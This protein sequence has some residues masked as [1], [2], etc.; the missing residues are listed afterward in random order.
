MN[1]VTKQLIKLVIKMS[2]KV[3]L[4]SFVVLFLYI[5]KAASG[6]EK[7]SN[8]TVS[9]KFIVQIDFST[10]ISNSLKVSPDNRRI[11]YVAVENEKWFV[12]VDGKEQKQ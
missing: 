3:I 2:K 7:S 11:A 4:L 9:E 10:L 5:A 6:Q 8:R 1:A 12:V